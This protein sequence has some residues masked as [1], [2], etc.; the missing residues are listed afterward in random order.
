VFAL[1]LFFSLSADCQIVINEICPANDS[2]LYDEEGERPDWV[3]LYNNSANPVN[4]KDYYFLNDNNGAP[5][6]WSFPDHIL[7]A[8]SR[9]T[10]FFSLKNRKTFADHLEQIVRFDSVWKYLIPLAEPDTNWIYPTY[11]DTAWPSD[12]GGFGQED[13]DDSTF[14]NPCISIYLRKTFNITDTSL[15]SFGVFNI[16][17]DD[18]F[19]AYLN[20]KEIARFGVGVKGERQPFNRFAYI[21]REAQLYLGGEYETYY[22]DKDIIRNAL[23]NGTNVLAIQVHN[24][25]TAYSDMSAIPNLFFGVTQGTLGFPV[26]PF[27]GNGF[28]T[29]FGLSSKGETVSLFDPNNNFADVIQYPKLQQENSYGRSADGAN[30]WCLFQSPTVNSANGG[31]CY[32]GYANEV[33]FSLQPGIY[34]SAQI[35]SLSSSPGNI[36]YSLDGSEPNVNSAL[37]AAPISLDSTRVVRALV[38]PVAPSLLPSS[39][40]TN[41]YFINE[42]FQLPVLSLTS[43]PFGLFDSLQGM[44]AYGPNADSVFPYH[45][46]NFHNE[47]ARNGHS[48]YFTPS[49]TLGFELDHQL[50]M[51]GGWSRGFPQKSFRIYAKD[52]FGS[53]EIDYPLFPYR[54]YEKIKNFNL[55][56][57]GLD[58]NSVHFR[59]I[60]MNRALM[61]SNLDVGD[62]RNCL[63]F[64]NGK[65][66]GVYEIRERYD[67]NYLSNIYNIEKDV[68]LI[69]QQ[70]FIHRGDNDDWLRMHR[71]ITASNMSLQ[72]N[73]DSIKK[74]LDVE[75]LADYF[76]AETYYV[77]N[78]WIGAY[79]YI[80]N[81]KF[82]RKDPASKWRY[83]LWDTDL[84]L[85]LD[86]Y[87]GYDLLS[88]AI[89]PPDSNPHSDIFRNLLTNL[90]FKNYFINRYADMINYHFEPARMIALAQSFRNVLIPEMSRHF[91]RWADTTI[92]DP[93]TL[94]EAYN[95]TSWNAKYSSMIGFILSRPQ[96]ARNFIQS[97]FLLQNQVDLILDVKPEG[98]GKIKISTIIPDAFPWQGTYFNGVPVKVTAIPNSGYTFHRWEGLFN[99]AAPV[100]TDTF[101]L[102]YTMSDQLTAYFVPNNNNISLTPNPASDNITI[103]FVLKEK[104][105]AT[106]EITD[107]TGR[108]VA[109]IIESK[110]CEAGYSAVSISTEALGLRQGIYFVTLKT[111]GTSMSALLSKLF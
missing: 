8:Y 110:M 19:V 78:D 63:V 4:L 9:L 77:N 25:D 21:S 46:A 68:D 49:G 50:R 92:A 84:G 87:F 105:R 99:L 24:R 36:Y 58:W 51:H 55:R 45:Y 73:Y 38:Y 35:L 43:P 7:P 67:E 89:S 37:Y 18:A 86:S 31:F 15:V 97:Q 29:S 33:S 95:I 85:G 109:K 1:F 75:N 20:G 91:V 101:T 96:Y 80:K 72:Q 65:Y 71:F 69:S 23:I 54:N 103:E 27:R 3:E 90:E 11:L 108:V 28:H 6:K 52:D 32:T 13:S 62:G 82:W 60:M 42:S 30:S 12:T 88:Y 111:N 64:L 107:I 47:W 41:T 57:A 5:E 53:A 14:I 66:W 98:A 56:N 79:S 16:D 61:N 59:D 44:Y 104:G 26:L 22:L 106:I 70:G 94:G 48:E 76:A 40:A 102:N 74:I 83:I 39:I 81:I 93:Y 2:L 10:V 100:M 17:Y 34:Q